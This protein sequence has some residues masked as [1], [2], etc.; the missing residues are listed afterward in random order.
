MLLPKVRFRVQVSGDP[1]A[2]RIDKRHL[3]LA[4][5]AQGVIQLACHLPGG[6]GGGTALPMTGKAL[7][8]ARIIGQIGTRGQHH[9]RFATAVGKMLRP[10]AFATG[11]RSA[12]QGVVGAA[13]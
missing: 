2:E 6:P 5:A 4:Q 10:A 3:L 8:P 11:R 13:R 9:N 12:D 7:L 1:S